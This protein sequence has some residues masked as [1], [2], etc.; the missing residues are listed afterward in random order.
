MQVAAEH[1]Q[2][3]G[4]SYRSDGHTSDAS[5]A[6][7]SLSFSASSRCH[8]WHREQRGGGVDANHIRAG[9]RC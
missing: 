6:E 3:H 7:S 8:G 4:A 2:Q 5:S 1:S 9:R